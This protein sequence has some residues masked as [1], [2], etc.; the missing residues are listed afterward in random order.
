MEKSISKREKKQTSGISKAHN[1][2]TEKPR[3]KDKCHTRKESKL[4]TAPAV[5]LSSKRGEAEVLSF[6]RASKDM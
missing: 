5:W 6:Y 3:V 2:T 4:D 1:V